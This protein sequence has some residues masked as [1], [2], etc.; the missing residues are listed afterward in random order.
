MHC[1]SIIRDKTVF[2]RHSTCSQCRVLILQTFLL[3]NY[4]KSS[5]WTKKIIKLLHVQYITYKHTRL[6][7]FKLIALLF[8]YPIYWHSQPSHISASLLP[9]HPFRSQKAMPFIPKGKQCWRREHEKII[10]SRFP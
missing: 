10:F 3:L 9:F 6:Q 8:R 1:T 4:G 2:L 5:E 7:N